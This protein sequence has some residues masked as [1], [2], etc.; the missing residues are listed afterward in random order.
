MDGL[1]AEGTGD[2]WRPESIAG[3][4]DPRLHHVSQGTGQQ[5][6]LVCTPGSLVLGQLWRDF[7]QCFCE[8]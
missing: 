1:M 7:P 5:E 8:P 4:L 6:P 3:P 2:I